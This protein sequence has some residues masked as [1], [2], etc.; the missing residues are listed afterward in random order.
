MTERV[1][2]VDRDGVVQKAAIPRDEV[3]NYPDLH[4]QIVITVIFDG[5]GRVLVHQRSP[6]KK[7][8]GGDIDHVCGGIVSG[9]TPEAAAAREAYEETGVRP[10]NLRIVAQGINEYNRYRY[11]LVGEAHEEPN[12]IEPDEVAWVGYVQPSELRTKQASGE[13]TFVDGFFEDIGLVG[14]G[15][16]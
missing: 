13:L 4:M 2:L 3:D 14:G 5:L 7:V 1:D 15:T 10:S 9:E 12:I 11:L 16:Q 8:N 6:K